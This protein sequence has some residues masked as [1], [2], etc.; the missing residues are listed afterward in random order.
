MN[1]KNKI[2]AILMASIVAMAVGMPMAIGAPATTSASVGSVAPTI[3]FTNCP[4]SVS[5]SPV[6]AA[7]HETTTFYLIGTIDDGNGYDD[8]T[9]VTCNASTTFG[10]YY[11][12]DSCAKSVTAGDPPTD[13]T[14]NCTIEVK[15]YVRPGAYVVMATVTDNGSK[16]GTDNC[17]VNIQQTTGLEL[18][19]DAIA[20]GNIVIG[21]EKELTGNDTWGDAA[22]SIHNTGNT[23]IDV[24]IN[25]SD[26][27]RDGG[28]VGTPLDTINAENLSARIDAVGYTSLV[29]DTDVSFNV[30]LLGDYNATSSS[31]E[32]DVENADFKILVNHPARV[33]SYGGTTIFTVAGIE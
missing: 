23:E 3:S 6:T 22:R 12:S 30:N 10:K 1:T 17:T 8:I 18:D 21:D 27:T 2:I 29:K 20:Y 11:V 33:G 26:M 14:F 5:P 32:D 13:G 7:N 25:A 9:G 16:T 4:K 31:Y 28:T 15:G 19:F 24:D